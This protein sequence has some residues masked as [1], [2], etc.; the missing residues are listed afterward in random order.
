MQRSMVLSLRE[1]A[2]YL[3]SHPEL[4]DIAAMRGDVPC[5]TRAQTAQIERIMG[6]FGFATVAGR[7]QL[8]VGDQVRRLGKNILISLI[9]FVRD[10]TALRVDTLKRVRVPIFISR[11]ALAERFGA[12]R[13]FSAGIG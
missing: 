6:R 11:R 8:S 7:V 12:I 2:A 13:E 5:G 9:V 3:S 1:L 4:C 10:A